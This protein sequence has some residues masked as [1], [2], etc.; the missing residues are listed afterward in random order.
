MQAKAFEHTSRV[1]KGKEL[2]EIHDS[3]EEAGPMNV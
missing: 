3:F 2:F 1:S